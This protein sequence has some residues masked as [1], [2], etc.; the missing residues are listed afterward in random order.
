[1]STRR[2][3]TLIEVALASVI[4]AVVLLAAMALVM[5][6]ERTQRGVA[7]RAHEAAQLQRS[8][9]VMQ[10]AFGSI[11]VSAPAPQTRPAVATATPIDESGAAAPGN[12]PREGVAREVDASDRGRRA[13]GEAPDRSPGSRSG[14]SSQ[15]LRGGGQ[16]PAEGAGGDSAAPS[17]GLRAPE[18]APPRV[19]LHQ[20][21]LV[22]QYVMMVKEEGGVVSPTPPQR[23]E[24]VLIEPPVPTQQ[25]DP[26]VLAHAVRLETKRRGISHERAEEE[27]PFDPA[28]E[29]SAESDDPDAEPSEDWGIRAVRGAFELIP[30]E[31]RTGRVTLDETG[32][33]KAW[34]L[35]WVPLAPRHT[36]EE[37]RDMGRARAVLEASSYGEPFKIAN[38]LASCRFRMF[39]DRVRKSEFEAT[40]QNQLPAYVEVDIATVGGQT[41]SWL[42]EVSWATGPETRPPVQDAVS[43][44]EAGMVEYQPTRPEGDKGGGAPVAPT[45]P[46]QPATPVRGRSS[47]KYRVP[48]ASPIT[49][50]EDR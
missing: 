20:D 24:L 6:L 13:P 33:P 30:Q 46:L 28:A 32:N 31:D 18:N 23:L 11:L 7:K 41:A 9:L 5:T 12:M 17:S 15:A 29:L 35:W 3:F 43:T 19:I 50:K 2:G 36:I 26:F 40:I 34:E 16:Q 14:A 4:G 47:T 49:P 25:P 48:P 27:A 22:S 44:A 37:V 21:A 10:R 45:T 39:D 8:R 1:V 38:D 42:F